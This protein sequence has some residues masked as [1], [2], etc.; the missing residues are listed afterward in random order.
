LVHF[1][2]TAVDRRGFNPSIKVCDDAGHRIE[3]GSDRRRSRRQRRHSKVER[4]LCNHVK[5]DA[6]GS[7]NGSLQNPNLA[8]GG[9]ETCDQQVPRALAHG[10]VARHKDLACSVMQPDATST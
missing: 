4:S 7:A 10:G 2:G 1:E 3:A 9:I 5:F 8:D 6:V